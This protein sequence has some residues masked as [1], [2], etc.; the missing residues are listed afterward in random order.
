[1]SLFP[2]P[3]DENSLFQMDTHDGILELM[4]IYSISL[5]MPCVIFTFLCM[6]QVKF[7]QNSSRTIS[8]V[9]EKSRAHVSGNG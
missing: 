9:V 8:G 7:Q 3:S 5:A 4:Y 1:M 6:F 2:D